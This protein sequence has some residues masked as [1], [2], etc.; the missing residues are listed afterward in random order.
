M[1]LGIAER[2]GEAAWD[3]AIG[4]AQPTIAAASATIAVA[5]AGDA[6]ERSMA[7]IIQGRACGPTAATGRTP[8]LVTI[9]P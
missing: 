1:G 9:G 7:R 4:V 2:L 5:R 3:D 8:V 6:I